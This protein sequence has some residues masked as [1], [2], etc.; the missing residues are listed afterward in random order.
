MEH[1]PNTRPLAKPLISTRSPRDGYLFVFS[2]YGQGNL[3]F[4]AFTWSPSASSS[5]KES[6]SSEWQHLAHVTVDIQSGIFGERMGSASECLQAPG[7][8]L[9]AL[10]S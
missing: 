8:L 7:L 3:C 6:S 1:S 10:D 2:F 5:L 9:Y 4:P